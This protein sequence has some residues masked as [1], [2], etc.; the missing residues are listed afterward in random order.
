MQLSL[1]YRKGHGVGKDLEKGIEWLLLAAG[2]V[3]S[4][5]S[6]R[7]FAIVVLPF[8]FRSVLL[9]LSASLFR[10]A[11]FIMLIVAWFLAIPLGIKPFHADFCTLGD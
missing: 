8:S 4:I 2:Q 11:L 6:A 5:V 10:L 1:C 7:C 9:R 3:G